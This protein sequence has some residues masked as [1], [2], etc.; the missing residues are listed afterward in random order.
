MNNSIK[1]HARFPAEP[2][3]YIVRISDGVVRKVTFSKP[4]FSGPSWSLDGKVLYAAARI[5]GETQIYLLNAGT[6]A[7][8]NELS[9]IANT[10]RR[11]RF[12]QYASESAIDCPSPQLPVTTGRVVFEAHGSGF[13]QQMHDRWSLLAPCHCFSIHSLL[14]TG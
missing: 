11:I 7:D 4:G 2:Q 10:C 9:G 6:S 8:Q 1:M 5:H 3:L 13:S 14:V 12:H